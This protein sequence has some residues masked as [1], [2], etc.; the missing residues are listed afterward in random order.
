[1]LVVHMRLY[2]ARTAIISADLAGCAVY[3]HRRHSAAGFTWLERWFET[4]GCEES[5]HPQGPGG[6]VPDLKHLDETSNRTKFQPKK[7]L[8]SLEKLVCGS[9]PHELAQENE[10]HSSS[11]LRASFKCMPSQTRNGGPPDDLANT[12]SP[13]AVQ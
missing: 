9:C 13:V 5:Y 4:P 8:F 11:A 1:M 3:A 10:R 6:D 7:T 12:T 2:M